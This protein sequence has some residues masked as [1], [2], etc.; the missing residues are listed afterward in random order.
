MHFLLITHIHPKITLILTAV[1]FIKGSLPILSGPFLINAHVYTPCTPSS[2]SS[3]P[4]RHLAIKSLQDVPNLPL[5]SHSFMIP[6]ITTTQLTTILHNIVTLSKQ[7]SPWQF[8]K[9][10]PNSEMNERMKSF[11]SCSLY[12]CSDRPKAIYA[13]P[14]SLP[15]ACSL[16]S[17]PTYPPFAQI[18]STDNNVASRPLLFKGPP[19]S[20]GDPMLGMSHE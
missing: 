1:V 17:R 10:T 5:L 6:K 7:M 13:A 4:K 16:S 3:H 8:Q 15:M 18:H 9:S 19:S 2:H 12:K 11:P 14:Q 20:E